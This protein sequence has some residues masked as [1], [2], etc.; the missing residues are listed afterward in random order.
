MTQYQQEIIKAGEPLT[1]NFPFYLN[2]YEFPIDGYE[3]LIQ[4]RKE[5]SDGPVIQSWVDG[6]VD[7]TR[8]DAG[9]KISLKLTPEFTNSLK[10]K[11]AYMDCWIQKQSIADGI[12]SDV[13]EFTLE[14]G[15]SR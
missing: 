4:L 3:L 1:I 7:V 11:T 13:I 5:S 6:D 8:I 9:G 2:G 12:R 10:F 15:V 14:R